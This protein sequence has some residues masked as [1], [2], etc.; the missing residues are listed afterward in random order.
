MTL[1]GSTFKFVS[2]GVFKMRMEFCVW[3]PCSRPPDRIPLWREMSRFDLE[4]GV[5]S[6]LCAMSTRHKSG[7]EK[8]RFPA[9]QLQ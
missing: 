4:H 9:R 6:P 8:D 5:H 7:P 1:S 3:N 2:A